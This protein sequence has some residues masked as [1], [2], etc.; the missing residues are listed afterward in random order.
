MWKNNYKHEKACL[1]VSKINFTY[2]QL[3]LSASQT[4]KKIVVVEFWGTVILRMMIRR[5]IKFSYQSTTD[6]QVDHDW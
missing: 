3:Y 1:S 2:S 5:I 6:I 4:I